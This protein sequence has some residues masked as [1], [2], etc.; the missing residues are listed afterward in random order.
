MKDVEPYAKIFRPISKHITKVLVKI[1]MTANEV[2]IL[3]GLFG[4][5]GAILFAYQQYLLGCLFLQIGFILDLCD[6]EVARH[7]GEET[8]SGE[9]L[10]KIQHRIVIPLY[11]FCL[12]IGTGH[13]IFGFLAGLFS[14]KFVSLSQGKS[15]KQGIKWFFLYPGSMVIITIASFFGGIEALIMFY[16]VTIPIGRFLQIYRTFNSFDSP[17]KT[18][19]R[20]HSRDEVIGI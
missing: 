3:Q 10:D 2:T 12:G 18:T 6:G 13:I 20:F 17:N 19:L 5:V 15:G 8:V 4:V 14:Q 7:F 11:F 9:Y 16:G 1:G